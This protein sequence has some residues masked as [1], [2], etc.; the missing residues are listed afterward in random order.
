MPFPARFASLLLAAVAASS[1]SSNSKPTP[2]VDP[3]FTVSPSAIDFSMQLMTGVPPEQLIQLGITSPEVAELALSADTPP[4]AWLDV[5]QATRSDATWTIPLSVTAR[6]YDLALGSHTASLRIVS[7]RSDHSLI[8]S[9]DV[10]VHLMLVND[11]AARSLLDDPVLMSE[12]VGRTGLIAVEGVGFTWHATVDQPWITLDPVDAISPM[13]LNL[14]IDPAGLAPGLHQATVTV[15]A[16]AAQAGSVLPAQPIDIPVRIALGLGYL[17]VT[18]NPVVLVGTAGFPV[19]AVQASIAMTSGATG[20][21]VAYSDTP[22]LH[23]DPVS[24][25]LPGTITVS[26]DGTAPAVG[27]N[28]T[29]FWVS[30]DGGA[31]YSGIGAELRWSP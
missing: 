18:P 8:S 25:T 12:W 10:P 19:P 4:P 11:F 23:L 21:W 2:T 9:R 26:V 13:D 30:A 1:C 24:G 28:S 5:G 20:S 27:T 3:G 29:W 14:T 16:T 22:W 17:A 15:A 7:A 31:T 6:A